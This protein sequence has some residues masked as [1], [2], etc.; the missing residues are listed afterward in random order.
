MHPWPELDLV[1][2]ST[3][4]P[5]TSIST[6]GDHTSCNTPGSWSRGH[7]QRLRAVNWWHLRDPGASAQ[8]RDDSQLQDMVER[9]VGAGR[10]SGK[11][12]RRDRSVQQTLKPLRTLLFTPHHTRPLCAF[13]SHHNTPLEAP[14]ARRSVLRCDVWE[15]FCKPTQ[16]MHAS[17]GAPERRYPPA[18]MRCGPPSGIPLLHIQPPPVASSR[19]A[20]CRR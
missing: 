19:R 10:G 18:D 6:V 1:V 17:D 7:S 2:R 3:T 16:P 15:G 8:D 14:A 11:W 20:A 9:R 13:R 5:R 12:L 4:H